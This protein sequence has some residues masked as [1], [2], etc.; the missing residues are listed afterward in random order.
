LPGKTDRIIKQSRLVANWSSIELEASVLRWGASQLNSEENTMPPLLPV[1]A[2]L[3][4]IGGILCILLSTVSGV[5]HFGDLLLNV[6]EGLFV[7]GAILFTVYIVS[8]IVRDA[9]AM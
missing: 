7:L 3:S 4:A 9:R 5:S 2:I 6:A 1:L 8:G